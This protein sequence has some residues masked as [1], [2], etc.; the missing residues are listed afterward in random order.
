MSH[1]GKLYSIVAFTCLC[2]EVRHMREI[3]IQDPLPRTV[4][5]F[6]T[7]FD[8]RTVAIGCPLNFI[9][10]ECKFTLFTVEVTYPPWRIDSSIDSRS[11]LVVYLCFIKLTLCVS[12]L[13]KEEEDYL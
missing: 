6:E 2:M 4:F 12:P 1:G 9:L 7:N 13:F 8:G 10:G 11:F 3:E 5:K